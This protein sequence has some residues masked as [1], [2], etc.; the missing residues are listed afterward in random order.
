MFII[1][2]FA[3]SATTNNKTKRARK[4]KGPKE[5]KRMDRGESPPEKKAA[6]GPFNVKVTQYTQINM[7]ERPRDAVS[8]KAIY[9]I[10]FHLP[11]EGF[12]LF[13]PVDIYFKVNDYGDILYH[14]NQG[15]DIPAS[16]FPETLTTSEIS[17]LITIW[18]KRFD[19]RTYRPSR[20]GISI[21][22]P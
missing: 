10:T 19:I 3:M 13:T 8:T 2:T 1:Y 12:K 17:D 21:L 11:V 22:L 18:S 14:D 20:S 5:S 7:P 4:T 15:V 9:K 6:G 16:H